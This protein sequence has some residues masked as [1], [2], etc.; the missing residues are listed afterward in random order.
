MIILSADLALNH[1]GIV[2]FKNNKMIDY[3]VIVSPRK[4]RN[5]SNDVFDMIRLN[6]ML[7]SVDDIIKKHKIDYSI[8]EDYS[9]GSKSSSL[10]QIGGFIEGVKLK[11]FNSKIPIRLVSPK[12]GKLFATGDGSA[13][14]EDMV[15]SVENNWEKIKF[16]KLLFP[17]KKKISNSDLGSIEDLCD[18][19]ALGVLLN[20]ELMLRKGEISLKDLEEHQIKVFNRVTKKR[21]ENIL[22]QDFIKS[23]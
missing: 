1:S 22:F 8:I 4:C 14:K 9:F 7:K 23:E 5:M 3:Y 19:Y 6:Y 15:Y 13:S 11:L 18:A 10:F 16:T 2:I 17:K 12:T 21:P 20:T